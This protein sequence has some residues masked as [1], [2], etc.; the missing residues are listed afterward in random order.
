VQG[1]R[2]P[3]DQAPKRAGEYSWLSYDRERRF[4]PSTFLG[5]GEWQLCGP[6]GRGGAV[7]RHW[8]ETKPDGSKVE[9]LPQHTWDVHEDRS[10]TFS[11]SLVMPSGW[12]GFLL[13]GVWS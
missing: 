4:W 1:V 7:G 13:R 10:V 8:I 2:L 3:D 5:E 6:D 12:H 9:H 11:P